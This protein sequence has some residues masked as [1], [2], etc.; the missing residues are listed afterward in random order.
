MIP[1]K[2]IGLWALLLTMALPACK[3]VDVPAGTPSCIKNKIRKIENE[4]VRNPPA[5]VWQYKYNGKT[6]YYIPPYCCDATS[7]L[8][9]DKCNLLCRPDGG[10]SGGGDGKC[11]DFFANRTD[12]KLIWKDKR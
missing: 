10:F 8:Y 2:K 7:E 6:V 5:T 9:D 12:E 4:G 3:K 1:L 11:P